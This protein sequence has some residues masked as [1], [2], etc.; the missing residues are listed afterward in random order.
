[1]TYL[2]HEGDDEEVK[3]E[4]DFFCRLFVCNNVIAIC[5]VVKQKVN[6]DAL[7]KGDFTLIL[8]YFFGP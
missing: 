6:L 1:M 5:I 4:N 3:K 2:H 7:E 8:Y